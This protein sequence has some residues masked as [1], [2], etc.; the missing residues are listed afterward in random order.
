MTACA[1]MGPQD[2]QPVCPCRMKMGDIPG[3]QWVRFEQLEGGPITTGWP[4]A[5]L[6]Q[7]DSRELSKAL[8]NT[9]GA[10]LSASDAGDA[11]REEVKR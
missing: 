6:M 5:V 3:Q 9:P 2:G 8:S 11:I 7:D 1:C 10:R 4:P